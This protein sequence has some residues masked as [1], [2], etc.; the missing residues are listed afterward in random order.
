MI[1][2]LSTN[3][4]S[5]LK[6]GLKNVNVLLTSNKCPSN[7]LLFLVPGNNIVLE[8]ALFFFDISFKS[9]TDILTPKPKSFVKSNS[10]EG[11]TIFI[12][13]NLTPQKEV[14]FL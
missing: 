5:V 10:P 14:L 3:L 6:L 13:L 7:W 11:S 8:Y 4:A 2:P 1:V 12:V 9:S